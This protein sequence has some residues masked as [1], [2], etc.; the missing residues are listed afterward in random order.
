VSLRH[1]V[2]GALSVRP[3]S[4][5]ELVTRFNTSLRHVWFASQGAI[6]AEVNRLEAD[7][8]VAP[9]ETG[10][11]GRTTYT[12][13]DAGL[14]E[15]RDWLLA[16]PKRE[17]RSEFVLRTFS[18]WLLDDA[19]ALAYLDTLAE[20]YRSR[21]AEYEA[22]Q[23][24]VDLGDRRSFFSQVSLRSG[25]AHEHAALAWVQWAQEAIRAGRAEGDP[26]LSITKT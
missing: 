12:V 4:G 25:I 13:T 8:L 16:P 1:A 7:G 22:M 19:E 5:Y 9:S 6:Y 11:R 18:L 20:D 3:S 2:L 23:V 15:L 24:D 10:P 17:P 14:S 21:L 26:P